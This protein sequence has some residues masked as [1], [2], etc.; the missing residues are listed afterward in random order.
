MFLAML[1]LF[2]FCVNIN[3]LPTIKCKSLVNAIIGHFSFYLGLGY[4][5]MVNAADSDI[6]RGTVMPVY[7]FNC[8]LTIYSNC[9]IHN[10]FYMM[11]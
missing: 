6:V 9:T 1:P 2:I 8:S 3:E 11:Q 10:I 4:L 5:A 7:M